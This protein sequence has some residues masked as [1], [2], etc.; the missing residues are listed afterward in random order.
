V[1]ADEISLAIAPIIITIKPD[2]AGGR[3]AHSCVPGIRRGSHGHRRNL[4]RHR[5]RQ[6]SQRNL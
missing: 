5:R 3:R 6:R 4:W 1:C 2:R